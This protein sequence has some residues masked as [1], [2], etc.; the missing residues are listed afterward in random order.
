MK[1]FLQTVLAVVVGF[2]LVMLLSL[3]LLGG[4]VGSLVA[5]MGD[6]PPAP[7]EDQT[8]LYL[9]LQQPIRDRVVE[10]PLDLLREIESSEPRPL[11]LF[12]VLEAISKAREDDRVVG[13]VLQTSGGQVPLS[14]AGELRGELKAFRESGKF[15]YAY[16]DG[17]NAATYYLASV[18]DSVM[19]H[20]MGSLEWKGFTS[21]VAYLKDA[22]AQFGIEPQVI[23]HGKYKSAVEP[24]LDSKMSPAN[25]QQIGRFLGSMWGNL[26]DEVSASRSIPTRQLNQLAD[27]LMLLR[28]EQAREKGLV[29]ALLYEDQLDSIVC[30]RE[31]RSPDETP[32]V[33]KLSDY[34]AGMR[35]TEGIDFEADKIAVVYAQG[36]IKDGKEVKE[37]IGGEGFAGVFDELRTDQRVKAVV[38]RINSPGGSALASEKMYRALARLKAQKPLVVSMGSYAASGGY[39][40]AAPADRIIASPYT[41]TGSIGVFGMYL[42]FGKLTREKLRINMETVTTNAHSDFGSLYRPLDEQERDVI[43]RSIKRTYD[44]FLRRV[45]EGRGMSTGDVDA[46]GQGRVWTG[47]DAKPLRLV[48]ELGGLRDAIALAAERAGL[49]DYR[50]ST[51]P[52]IK[53]EPY[54]Q[55]MDAVFKTKAGLLERYLP[56][57]G[58]EATF[59]H[60]VEALVSKQGIRAE[61]PVR[62]EVK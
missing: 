3:L 14:I 37:H 55:I 60:G 59:R 27:E 10:R 40:M 39:Y 53:R 33:T 36:D 51:Y 45:A 19:L 28:P 61:L 15:V 34:V 16:S 22:C 18:A 46:I 56:A 25:R 21:T 52:Q 44:V 32:S 5:M 2:F 49:E 13:I 43:Q 20:P 29:D 8:V 12:D 26:V 50:L 54:E 62:F 31:G 38:L 4:V 48:D 9:N 6:E 24:F 23:R 1:S 57:L 58:E 41:L 47:E 42:T 7:V 17:Y 30:V 11:A 35:A